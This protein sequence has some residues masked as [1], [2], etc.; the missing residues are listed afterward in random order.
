MNPEKFLYNTA[1][2]AQLP[3]L[4]GLS[5]VSPLRVKFTNGLIFVREV[6]NIEF[7]LNNKA[8]NGLTMN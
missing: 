8:A 3:C 7:Q 2:P 1:F 4:A 6:E 5:W